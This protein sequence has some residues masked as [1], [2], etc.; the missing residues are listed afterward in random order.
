MKNKNNIVDWNYV[1][2]NEKLTEDF[3]EKHKDEVNWDHIS[4]CQIL[5]ESF[6]EKF[7]DKVNFYNNRLRKMRSL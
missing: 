7:K 6:I 4:M 2:K 1:S 3:I 5:S